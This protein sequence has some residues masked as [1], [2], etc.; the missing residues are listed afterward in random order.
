MGQL[1]RNYLPVKTQLVFLMCIST[2]SVHMTKSCTTDFLFL[3]HCALN[4]NQDNRLLIWPIYHMLSLLFF[5]FF[6]LGQSKWNYV[7]PLLMLL[8]PFCDSFYNCGSVRGLHIRAKLMFCCFVLALNIKDIKV[9]QGL[10]QLSCWKLQSEQYL[11]IRNGHVHEQIILCIFIE[12]DKQKWK[13]P[14]QFCAHQKYYKLVLMC[15]VQFGILS[16]L[17]WRKGEW[18]L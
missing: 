8:Q 6:C 9:I 10:S 3:I 2:H 5:F 12:A 18:P 15:Y 4:I 7:R 1:L 16:I 13:L 11:L 14:D 17:Y